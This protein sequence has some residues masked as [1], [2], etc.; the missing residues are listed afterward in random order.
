MVSSNFWRS[1][2]AQIQV[3]GDQVGEMAG[4]LGVQRGDLDLV[5]QRGG[6]LGDFLE[7]LVRVAQHRLQLDGILRL[8]AQQF[9]VARRYG[10]GGEK[11]LMRMRQSPSTS[12][13][14]VPSGNFTILD[15]RV[16]QPTSCKSSGAGS[17]TSGLRCKHRAEQTVA[18]DDVVNQLEA[19]P[20]LD[21]QRHD[22][23]GKNHDVRKAEDG[24]RLS[25]SEREEMRDGTFPI[26]RR[27][28]NAD[29]F[30]FRR[31][32]RRSIHRVRLPP[33]RKRFTHGQFPSAIGTLV[34]LVRL[35][36][37]RHVNPQKAV[38]I[39]RLGLAQIIARRQFQHVS[40]GP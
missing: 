25:G 7:L 10:A 13:R 31:C 14:A 15:R 24:Q 17:A 23:A 21:E 8:V 4:M 5:G 40:N 37:R 30:C 18:G 20:G 33:R 12:T 16:T 39:N 28:Q 6:H 2:E 11:F 3:R 34:V 26:F 35:V 19:R 27:A 22:G 36:R 1:S 9:V 29:K 38:H 32:C